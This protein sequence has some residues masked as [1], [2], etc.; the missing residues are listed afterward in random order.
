MSTLFA[1]ASKPLK[2]KELSPEKVEQNRGELIVVMPKVYLANTQEVHP[3][4][5]HFLKILMSSILNEIYKSEVTIGGETKTVKEMIDCG[6]ENCESKYTIKITNATIVSSAS[7]TW[8]TE[9]LDFTHKNNGD[10][11]KDVTEIS[12]SGKNPNN[13]KLAKNRANSLIQLVMQDLGKIKKSLFGLKFLSQGTT[14]RRMAHQERVRARQANYN[15][16]N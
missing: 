11:I 16:R 6:T 3:I 4:R 10:K 9:V 13:L 1:R 5:G 8:T 7:N 12:P 2:T 15:R 14:R